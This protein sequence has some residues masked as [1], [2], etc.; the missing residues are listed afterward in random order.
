[1]NTNASKCHAPECRMAITHRVAA[2]RYTRRVFMAEDITDLAEN[3]VFGT[4]ISMLVSSSAQR[5]TKEKVSCLSVRLAVS[6]CLLHIVIF[7][8]YMVCM[9]VFIAYSVSLTCI[10]CYLCPCLSCV[11]LCLPFSFSVSFLCLCLCLFVCL[12][13]SFPLSPT[14]TLSHSHF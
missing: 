1:M 8:L 5:A 9:P 3:A 12:S 7:Y 10:N 4:R 14:H 13:P 11:P 2:V 6:P